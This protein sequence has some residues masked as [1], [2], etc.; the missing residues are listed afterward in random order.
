MWNFGLD[1]GIGGTTATLSIL[2]IL[3][4]TVISNRLCPVKCCEFQIPANSALCKDFL[5]C[6]TDFQ[7]RVSQTSIVNLLNVCSPDLID[8]GLGLSKFG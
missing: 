1:F 6:H 2:R 5:D 4:K 8:I 7:S 3:C